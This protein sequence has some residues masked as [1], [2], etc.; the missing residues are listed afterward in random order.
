MWAGIARI[1]Q[2]I[3]IGV[4]LEG[5]A[6]IGAIVACVPHAIEV[7][8]HLRGVEDAGTIVDRT[9][10]GEKSRVTKTVAV[11]IRA[12][13][14]GISYPIPITVRRRKGERHGDV[15]YADFARDIAQR[16]AQRWRRC[17]QGH[18]AQ[19]GGPELTV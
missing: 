5:I 10:I 13:V 12:R 6:R 3:A 8:I 14:G 11:A 15:R 4:L 9:G 18:G 7:G 2:S 1:T 17:S 19:R 16:D